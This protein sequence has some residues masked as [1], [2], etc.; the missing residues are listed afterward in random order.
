MD[1]SKKCIKC[2]QIKTLD[3]F[4]KHKNKL[5]GRDSWCRVC[6]SI[7]RNRVEEA[8]TQKI[9]YELFKPKLNQQCRDYKRKN[10]G[11]I[12]AI[13]ANRYASKLLRMPK[14]LT[15]DDKKLIKYFYTMAKIWRL[16]LKVNLGVWIDIDVDHVVPMQG[17]IVSGLHVP[18]NLQLLP[19]RI[20]ES[21]RNKF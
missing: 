19:A 16:I 14:W 6:K 8:K 18:W 17:A 20:N 1:V 10:P 15:S 5:H 21:K 4:N 3:E 12:N 2:L 11:I 9:R 7:Y 13:N